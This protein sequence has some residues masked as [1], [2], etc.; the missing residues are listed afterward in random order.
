MIRNTPKNKVIPSVKHDM[1][2][3]IMGGK[4]LSSPPKTPRQKPE[5]GGTIVWG[6]RHSPSRPNTQNLTM[7]KDKHFKG[8]VL[9]QQQGQV[10]VGKNK[11][12]GGWEIS[13]S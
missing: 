1:A 13:K 7:K 3:R 6:S 10:G 12:G 8:G 9:G 2:K 11:V 5:H 4:L